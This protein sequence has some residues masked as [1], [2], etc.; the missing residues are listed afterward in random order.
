MAYSEDLRRCVLNA[1]E[2]GMSKM[3]AHRTFGVSR[4]TIDDWFHLREQSG[5][6]KPSRSRR[7]KAPTIKDLVAF[8]EFAGRHGHCTLAQMALAWQKETGVALTLLP[9][10]MALRR[11][12][13]TRKKEL[14][15]PRAA[16]SRARGFR[17]S[18]N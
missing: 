13:W 7:G 3:Q 15:L 10:S 8:A 16:P 17:P 12:G 2:G 4:T 5:G 14:S 18:L 9:F 11:I 6:V 1:I